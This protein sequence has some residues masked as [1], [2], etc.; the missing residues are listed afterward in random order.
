MRHPSPDSAAVRRRGSTRVV[1]AIVLLAA[2]ALAVF[3]VL[4]FGLTEKAQPPRALGVDSV[5]LSAADFL[6]HYTSQVRAEREAAML[7]LLGVQDA[8]E[9]RS[10]CDYGTIKSI[11]LREFVFEHFRKQSPQALQRRAA[12]VIE[13]ALTTSFP[14]RSG[15]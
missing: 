6:R 4:A 7:Y 15:S 1:V 8:T 13:E 12:H 2:C 9:G 5:N 10:W 3:G 14:C 11:T